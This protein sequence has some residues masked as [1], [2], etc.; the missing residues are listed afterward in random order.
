ML[1]GKFAS[2]KC[3]THPLQSWGCLVS[4]INIY[5]V[6]IYLAVVLQ[7]PGRWLLILLFSTHF[8]ET[9][10]IIC[11]PS[12][13]ACKPKPWS[14]SS[15]NVED[16]LCLEFAFFICYFWISE[17]SLSKWLWQQLMIQPCVWTE[18]TLGLSPTFPF[19]LTTS[20]NFRYRPDCSG[21]WILT[22]SV[23]LKSLLSNI[24]FDIKQWISH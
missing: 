23:F 14:H 22:H 19:L 11:L 13:E 7:L 15:Y 18:S 8:Q 6:R 10:K 1:F 9:K 2:K 5:Y 17:P 4:H 12:L 21:V 16:F 20:W 3:L 24:Q